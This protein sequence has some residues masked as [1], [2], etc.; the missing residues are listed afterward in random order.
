M[1]TNNYDV[2]VIGAGLSGLTAASLLAKRKLK[3]AVFDKNYNPGGSCGTFKRNDTIFDQGAAMLYGFGDKGYNSH[4]FVFNCLEQPIDVIKHDELYAVN[5]KG[6]HIV[7]HEDMS[8]FTEELSKIFPNE[9]DGIERLYRDLSTIYQHVMIEVPMFASPDEIDPKVAKNQVLKHPLSY[10]KFLSYLNMSTERLLKKYFKGNEILQFF[11]KLTSTYSY[12]TVKETPAVLAAVMFVD[13]HFGGSY[14]TAGSTMFLPGKLEKAIEENDGVMH[15]EEVVTSIIFDHKKA[16]GVTT[17]KGNKYYAENIVFSGNVWD[18]YNKLI[19]DKTTTVKERAKID[20]LV[21]SYPSSMIYTLV[22]KE[23]IPEGTLPIE[24]IVGDPSRLDENEVTIYLLSID[25]HSVCDEDHH[26]VSAIGP[27][28]TNWDFKDE[29]SYLEAKE[30]E[31]KRLLNVLEKRFPG[32]IKSVDYVELATSKTLT[33]YAMKHEG[34][35]AGPKQMMGQHMFNR[36]HIRTKWENLYCCGESTAMGTGTPSVTVSGLTAA[37]VILRK[38]EL[39]PFIYRDNMPN[40][41]NIVP[42]PFTKQDLYKNET[43]ENKEIMLS[44]NR[45]QCCE[46]PLCMKNT[47]VDIRGIMRR[48]C[49][50]NFVGAK[51]LLS[52]FNIQS[53]EFYD[54][55]LVSE[56]NCI[57]NHSNS[58][59]VAIEKIIKY[60]IK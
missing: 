15:Y 10:L 59:P 30:R 32:F 28:F 34:S 11:D 21:W 31:T 35:V 24:M 60:L 41:V 8:K 33:R 53:K 20:K 25:D 52:G 50:G 49:V 19:E 2:I 58:K 54:S 22:R 14:Y 44:A 47:N 43:I 38:Y 37:N 23:V 1:N 42:H 55:L 29:K 40:Y 9:K 7:F 12:T 4:R 45:C 51:K 16:I 46:N 3:V 27:S 48:V 57:L 5:F 56:A 26:V 17:S 39:E 13:N 18:L 36:Q 6:N